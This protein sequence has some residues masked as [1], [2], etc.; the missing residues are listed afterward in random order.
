LEN[1]E[2]IAVKVIRKKVLASEGVEIMQYEAE[3]LKSI[4]HP[5]V[6]KFKHVSYFA[7]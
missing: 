1:G 5:Q 2:E 6:V 3:I 7:K 4:D